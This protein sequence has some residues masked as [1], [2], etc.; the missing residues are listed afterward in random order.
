MDKKQQQS[1]ALL[2]MSSFL[3]LTTSA[4][5]GGGSDLRDFFQGMLTGMG[6]VSSLLTII[7]F[8][9]YRKSRV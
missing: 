1:V 5:S 7:A 2:A 8:A 6:I 3:L 9:K 4:I